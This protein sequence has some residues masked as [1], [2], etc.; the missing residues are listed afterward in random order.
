MLL[1]GL[2]LGVPAPTSE[3]HTC[4][5]DPEVRVSGRLLVPRE[6]G[7]ASIELPS[8]ET[9]A[10]PIAPSTGIATGVVASR[11]GAMLAVPRFWRPPDHKVGGQDILFVGQGGGAPTSVMQRSQPGEVL[12]APAWLPD[13]SLVYERRLL[14]GANESVRIERGRPGDATGQV[15]AEDASWPG[16]SPDGSLLALV[17]F[18]GRDRLLVRGIDG[19]EERTLV[20]TPQLL[21]IAFPRFSPDGAWIAFTA[22]SDPGVGAVDPPLRP[23]AHATHGE[24]ASLAPALGD[25]SR[26][27]SLS[28]GPLTL[29][30][31]R[32]H[33][34]PWDVW[35]VRPDGTGL[36]RVTTFADDDSAVTWSPDGRWLLTLSAEAL[37]AVAFEGSENYCI[38]SNGGYGSLE[39]LTRSQESGARSQ[40][41]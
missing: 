11:D 19:G 26:L 6:S 30:V 31:A 32:A 12:G 20:E 15:L 9:R 27:A 17:R 1:A 34:V 4:T 22:A 16:V 29:R 38:S 39:W 36:R 14:A 23:A 3:A 21:S 33:G 13:G 2:L 41:G 8:R 28:A 10:I 35:V 18:S 37:H 25:L 5:P 40:E 24:L 7:L